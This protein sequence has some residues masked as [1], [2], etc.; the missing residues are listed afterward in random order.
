MTSYYLCG[1]GRCLHRQSCSVFTRG[2][3]DRSPAPRTRATRAQIEELPVCHL[4]CGVDS[5]CLICSDVIEDEAAVVCPCPHGHRLCVD[6]MDEHIR[7]LCTQRPMDFTSTCNHVA[8]P[9]GHESAF[10]PREFSR[11]QFELWYASIMSHMAQHTRSEPVSTAAYIS[12]MLDES[13]TMRCPACGLAFSDFDGCLALQCRCGACFCGLCFKHCDGWHDCHAHVRNCS[14]NPSDQSLFL[15]MVKWQDIQRTRVRD[16][17]AAHLADAAQTVSTTFALSLL[18]HMQ[19]MIEERG[20]RIHLSEVLS[21]S[22]IGRNIW[23][24]L[25]RS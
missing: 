6:C 2:R 5:V 17:L 1:Q 9:C 23:S 14:E 7:R 18:V 20:M 4:C 19:P 21:L 25:V 15:N 10:D 22:T 11:S 8:C 13:L 24:M 16:R 12:R 3:G